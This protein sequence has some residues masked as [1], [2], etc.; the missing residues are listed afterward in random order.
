[1]TIGIYNPYLDTL[2]GGERYCFDIARCLSAGGD[3]HIFWDDP[4]I[5][6]RARERFGIST[7]G[8]RLVRNIWKTGNVFTRTHASSAYD[9]IFYVSD[10]SIPFVFSKKAYLIFQ[11]PVA[12]KRSF[13][14]NLKLRNITGILCYSLFVKEFLDRQFDKKAIVLPPAVDAKAFQSGKKEKLIVSVGRFTKGKNTKKQ[15]FLIDIFKT[16]AKNELKN[17]RFVLAGGMLGKDENLIDSLRARAKGFQISVEPNI[18]FADLQSLYAKAQIY[19]HA[20]GYGEDLSVYPEKAEHFGLTTL[21]AM[22][23]GAVPVVFAGGGQ[24]EVVQDGKS[25]YLWQT[26]EDLMRMTSMLIRDAKLR[27]RVAQAGE[28]RAHDFSRE[29]FCAGVHALL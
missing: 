21:E 8:I 4:E 14:T 7:E 9:A 26:Q 25:G 24:K 20:A 2:G 3:V 15:E 19:W 10:G 5:L 12:V 11:F 17:W 27:S 28:R 22:S 13:L 16:L 18:S 23:A 29:R 6:T 1:M